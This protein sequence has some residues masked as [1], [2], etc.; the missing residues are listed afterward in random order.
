MEST[1]KLYKTLEDKI[2]LLLR[3]NKKT[4]DQIVDLE[5]EMSVLKQKLAEQ[6]T[7][8]E[9]LKD[10]NE[11]LKVA[12]AVGGNKEHRRLMKNKV[13]SLV[14]EIDKCIQLVDYTDR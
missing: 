4:K 5:V 6:R 1:K 14:K 11:A 13:N 3:V 10:K 12:N 8:N 9:E 7:I 2:L